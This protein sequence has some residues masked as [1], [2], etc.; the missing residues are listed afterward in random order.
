MTP[1]QFATMMDG[2]PARVTEAAEAEVRATVDAAAQFA[3][4][5]A[6]GRTGHLREAIVARVDG[7]TAIVAARTPYASFVEA[8]VG[9]VSSGVADAARGL[10]DRLDRGV[11]R[12]IDP[13]SR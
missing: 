2:A 11:T 3:R 10:P 7:L 4:S 1:A 5:R 6:P 8:E 9:M 12:A 13:V